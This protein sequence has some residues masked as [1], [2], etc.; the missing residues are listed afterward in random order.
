MDV[1]ERRVE[2]DLQHTVGGLVPATDYKFHILAT[3][4]C[5]KGNLSNTASAHTQM[6]G[7]HLKQFDFYFKIISLS[8]VMPM[9]RTMAIQDSFSVASREL[10][11]SSLN[12]SKIIIKSYL[13]LHIK[14]VKGRVR[15]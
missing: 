7:K 2:S 11:Q 9:F 13:Y 6:D 5:G 4:K 3:S 10:S 14:S 8:H 1:G 12:L 15:K